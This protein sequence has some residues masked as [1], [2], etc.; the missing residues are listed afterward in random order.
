LVRGLRTSGDDEELCSKEVK[1]WRGAVVLKRYGTAQVSMCKGE[2][3]KTAKC[4]KLRKITGRVVLRGA[5]KQR[6]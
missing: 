4:T 1:R 3:V 2:V 6:R 5:W